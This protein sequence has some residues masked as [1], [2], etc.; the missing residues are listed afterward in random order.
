MSDQHLGGRRRARYAMGSMRRNVACWLCGAIFAVSGMAAAAES[1]TQ[2]WG[3]VV[4]TGTAGP[5]DSALRYWLEGQGRFND[6]SSRFGQGIVRAGLGHTVGEN[7]VL[8]G[9]YAFIP[10]DP[11]E[12]SDDVVEHRLWQQWTWGSAL[13]QTAFTVSLRSRLEQRWIES[14]EDL[15]WRARQLLKLTRPLG[16]GSRFYVSL[17][18]ELFVN[19]NTTDWGAEAGV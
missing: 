10:T 11:L 17:W 13:P 5:T 4:A 18:D 14:A 19:I 2:T 9:G 15:G 12:R 16:D 3:A 7:A 8:W 6:D 1:D